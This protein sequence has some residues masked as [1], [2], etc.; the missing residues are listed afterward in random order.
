MFVALAVL[1]CSDRLIAGTID[2]TI[3][4]LNENPVG[5]VTIQAFELDE[6]G[7]FVSRV[8]FNSTVSDAS[9]A[10]IGKYSLDLMNKPRVVLRLSGGGSNTIFLPEPFIPN[11]NRGGAI[12]GRKNVTD[13]DIIVPASKPIVKC[14]QCYP[15]RRCC[16]R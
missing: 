6:R 16:R 2:G 10:T 7:N 15:R 3:L 4:D 9:G 8:P 12:S 14:Y 5:G 1:A 13:F 11:A